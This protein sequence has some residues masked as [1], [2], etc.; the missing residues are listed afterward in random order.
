MLELPVKKD[1]YGLGYHS[2]QR[3][4]RKTTMNAVKGHV[5]PL[6]DTFTSARHLIAGQIYG[7]EDEGSVSD[8]ICFVYRRTE[9]QEFNNWTSVE[10]EE[11]TLIEE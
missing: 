8:A 1:R 5:L 10:M 11:V 2:Q 4:P 3:A 6:P 7:V 9:G